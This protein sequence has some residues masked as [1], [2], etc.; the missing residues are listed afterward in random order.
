MT[1]ILV[2]EDEPSLRT[3][4]VDYL[5]MR[6]F[7]AEGAASARE[8][9]AALGTGEAPAIVILDI[10]LPD[11]SGFDLAREIRKQFDCGIIMLTA[12]NEADDRVR[13]FDSGADIYLVKHSSLR[14]IEATVNSLLRRLRDPNPAAGQQPDC[15]LLSRSSWQLQAPNRR[16]VKL[17][18]T[19]FAFIAALLDNTGQPCSRDAL[20]KVMARPQTTWDNR[21][22]DA[23]VN[24][25]R[26][27]IREHTNIEAPIRMIYGRGYA[28]SAPGQVE[29]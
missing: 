19:E 20:A 1:R 27:K 12:L 16:E 24:R 26:R 25:L 7:A 18:A 2:V 15:W 11:G 22:L 10:G 28:F 23:V 13:G 3:D 9:R 5:A 8:L 29:A 17:T 6:G 21:H 4:L 14:E